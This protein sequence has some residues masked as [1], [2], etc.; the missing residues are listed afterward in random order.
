[1]TRMLCLVLIVTASGCAETSDRL[2]DAS[3][4]AGSSPPQATTRRFVD[5]TWDTVW[6]HGG[7]AGDTTLLIPFAIS[8]AGGRVHVGDRAEQ[9]VVALD[10]ATGAV[11]WLSGRQ[12]AGPGEFRR[13]DA[14][15]AT[16]D[17]G[18]LV[19]D[20]GNGRIAVVDAGGRTR[21]YLRPDG[22]PIYLSLCPLADGAVAVGTGGPGHPV[23]LVD[24]RGAV[25][26]RPELPWPDLNG[27]YPAAPRQGLFAAEPGGAGCLYA[28]ALGRGFT[29]L[30]DGRFEAAHDYVEWFD[31]PESILTPSIPGQPPNERLKGGWA[32]AASGATVDGDEVTVAFWGRTKDRG[33]LLDVYSRSDGRYLRTVRAPVAMDRMAYAD[34]TWF[35]LHTRDGY[36]AVLAARPRHSHRP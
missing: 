1:M 12:G 14:I 28:L 34:G 5:V 18:V 21:D 7:N 33:R 3:R 2:H 31:V 20:G 35:F 24:R 8:A 4:S 36:P 30:A 13:M 32:P 29:R 25:V 6:M 11:E 22:I 23:V 10:A 17:G 19:A 26:G 27:M 16:A 9:R 15:A